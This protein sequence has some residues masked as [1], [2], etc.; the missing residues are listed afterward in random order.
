M[1]PKSAVSLTPIPIRFEVIDAVG[2]GA[3]L[4]EF[5]GSP[6][7]RSARDLLFALLTPSPVQLEALK[8]G[9]GPG[10]LGGRSARP[11]PERSGVEI[12]DPLQ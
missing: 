2:G 8:V 5:T 4:A 1:P 6:W 10:G 9:G 11:L 3:G 7:G 12:P